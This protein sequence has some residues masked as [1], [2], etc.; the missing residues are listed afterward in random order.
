MLFAVAEVGKLK[1]KVHPDDPQDRFW[2]RKTQQCLTIHKD[3]HDLNSIP[4]A[5]VTQLIHRWT[6]EGLQTVPG[7][8]CQACHNNPNTQDCLPLWGE[9][10][11][12]IVDGT[13]P[14]HLYF[15]VDTS[16]IAMKTQRRYFLGL[17]DWPFRLLFLG[18]NYTFLARGYWI[19]SHFRSKVVRK[20]AGTLG[21]WLQDNQANKGNAWLLDNNPSSIGGTSPDKSFVMYSR[22]WS[23]E[24]E[25]FINKQIAQIKKDHPQAK[26]QV[27][28]SHLKSLLID[29]NNASKKQ[30]EEL[31]LNQEDL[32]IGNNTN[33]L[34][35]QKIC[36]HC[37]QL[38][39]RLVPSYS[40]FTSNLIQNNF[41]GTV[42]VH[43]AR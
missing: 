33:H 12:E 25:E 30:T 9:T 32:S 2:S 16:T 36:F 14:P 15:A 21:V 19:G 24:E 17:Q 40:P 35:Y 13:P 11:L 28:F 20:V 27:P 3:L 10:R 8:H 42:T 43:N 34:H 4:Y 18:H 22:A 6:S 26:G 38:T 1:C 41:F 29:T 37:H 7:L 31:L 5:N 23:A 39:C